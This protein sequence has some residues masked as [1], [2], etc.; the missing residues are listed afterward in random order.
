MK[1]EATARRPHVIVPEAELPCTI[2]FGHNVQARRVVMLFSV[3]AT[4]LF[5]SPEE[6]D[7]V[8]AKLQHY[9]TL[10]RG[11]ISRTVMLD[12]RYVSHRGTDFRVKSKP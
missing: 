2:Q 9:A 3:P 11:E 10:A 8:A 1:K 7:D 12:K 4:Q 6:A 5:F